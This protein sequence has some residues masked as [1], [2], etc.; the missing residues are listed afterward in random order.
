MFSA[1]F[2]RACHPPY[3]WAPACCRTSWRSC[4]MLGHD[5]RNPLCFRPYDSD[6]TKRKN[7]VDITSYDHMYCIS[8]IHITHHKSLKTKLMEISI[9]LVYTIGWI[10]CPDLHLDTTGCRTPGHGSA[11]RILVDFA[12]CDTGFHMLLCDE[13]RTHRSL[14]SCF[15]RPVYGTLNEPNADL[16][17]NGLQLNGLIQFNFRTCFIH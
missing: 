3:R 6:I 2:P 11:P 10:G 9:P 13:D 1:S 16:E 8:M 5:V 17:Q 12:N 14:L 15:A 7:P 4:H